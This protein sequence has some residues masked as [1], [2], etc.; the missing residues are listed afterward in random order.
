MSDLGRA[1]ALAQL[2]V[3]RETIERLDVF[4]D[5]LWKWNSRINLV[6]RSTLDDLWVRHIL[7][8]AQLLEIAPEGKLWADFGSGGGFPGLVVAALSKDRF[9]DM[10]F[11]LVEADQRKC[12][13]LRTV[14]REC[15][16]P[17]EVQCVRIEELETVGAD[18]L[19]ARALADLSTLLGYAGTHLAREGRALFPKGKSVDNE[20]DAALAH[21]RFDCQKYPSKTDDEAVILSIGGISRV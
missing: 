7:D 6:S 12:T 5:L 10:E 14:I 1:A 19:S 18:I 2:D 3:P 17:A 4:A 21:W 13:F 20:I 8:S 16:L 15:D 11:R 9:P